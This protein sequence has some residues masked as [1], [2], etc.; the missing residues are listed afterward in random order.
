MQRLALLLCLAAGEGGGI[1]D[2]TYHRRPFQLSLFAY[3]PYVSPYLPGPYGLGLAARFTVPLLYRGFLP[4]VNDSFELEVGGN[5]YS[6]VPDGLV[7][8]VTPTVEAR[9]T[10]HVTSRFSAYPKLGM[11]LSFPLTG[12]RPPLPHF[13]ASV[14]M[15]YEL[16]AWLYFRAEAGYPGALLGLAFAF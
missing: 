11:G 7:Y 9:W 3:A 5:F 12:R 16:L 10:F 4:Q 6:D 8:V 14:G 1:R 15:L 13:T 2:D